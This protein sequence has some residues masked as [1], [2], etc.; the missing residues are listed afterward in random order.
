MTVKTMRRIAAQMMGVGEGSIR[1]DPEKVK[2]AEKSLTREDVRNLIK[3][4]AITKRPA[5]G[6]RK[7]RKKVRRGSGSRKGGWKARTGDKEVWMAKVRA[8]RSLL[9]QMV[10]DSA[11]DPKH[12][13]VIYNRIKAGLFKSKRALLTYLKDAHMLKQDYEPVKK[14]KKKA[15]RKAEVKPQKKA[16]GKGGK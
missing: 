7:A 15:R 3:N 2:E 13:R 6:R 1:F 11:L 4:K 9:S 16:E 10:A 5:K 14:Q 12:K 8:Q